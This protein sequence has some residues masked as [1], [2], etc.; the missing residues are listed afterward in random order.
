VSWDT[1]RSVRDRGSDLQ[2]RETSAARLGTRV[3]EGEVRQII[4]LA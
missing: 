1:P 2:V 4:G 3:A